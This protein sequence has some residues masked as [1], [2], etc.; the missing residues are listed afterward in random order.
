MRKP[1]IM[2]KVGDTLVV[3]HHEYRTARRVQVVVVATYRYRFVVQAASATDYLAEYFR[4]WDVRTGGPYGGGDQA[5][6]RSAEIATPAGW[7][8]RDRERAATK[9]LTDLGVRD[10]ELR[11]P[12]RSAVRSDPVRFVAVLSQFIVSVNEES[13]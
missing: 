10:W 11:E 8:V 5:S 12:L 6:S 9:A 7:A 13:K 4:E 2:P 1:M 3:E